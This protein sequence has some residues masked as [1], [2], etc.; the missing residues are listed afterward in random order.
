MQLVLWG[1]A[2]EAL[3]R[4]MLDITFQEPAL[5]F[6]SPEMQDRAFNR[7]QQLKEN[8]EK[9]LETDLAQKKNARYVGLTQT[10][11]TPEYTLPGGRSRWFRY[12]FGK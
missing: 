7:F 12:L 3:R 10:M 1:A 2:V 6:G 5:V 9:M 11:V 4:L 8:Y